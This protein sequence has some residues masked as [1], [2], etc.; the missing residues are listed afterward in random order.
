MSLVWWN[1]IWRKCSRASIRV[2]PDDLPIGTL[3]FV[4]FGESQAL[5]VQRINNKQGSLV[6][7]VGVEHTNYGEGNWYRLGVDFE[8]VAE[9][10]P[11][12]V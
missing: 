10:K 9:Y 7:L 2:I 12:V 11:E 5:S 1:L 8:Y 3:I 6:Q 4:R